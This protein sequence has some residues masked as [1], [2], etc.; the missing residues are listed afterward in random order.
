MNPNF[1]E[2]FEI[3]RGLGY[4]VR[5]TE[6]QL[7]TE[8]RIPGGSPPAASTAGTS[9][10]CSAVLER[11]ADHPVIQEILLAATKEALSRQPVGQDAR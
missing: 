3:F 2:V 9:T 10:S 4:E 1:I 11:R 8:Y 5:I 6:C 7:V